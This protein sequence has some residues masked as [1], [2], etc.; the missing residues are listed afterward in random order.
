ML[1]I[2]VE[3]TSSHS[4]LLPHLLYVTSHRIRI[5]SMIAAVEAI[6]RLYKYGDL[7]HLLSLSFL[8]VIELGTIMPSMESI[9]AV[10]CCR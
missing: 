3:A 2:A 7:M 5:T 6:T 8:W 10:S 4:V 9:H 1:V